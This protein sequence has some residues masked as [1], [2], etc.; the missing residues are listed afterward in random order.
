MNGDYVGMAMCWGP[1]AN[2][3]VAWKPKKASKSRRTESLLRIEVKAEDIAGPPAWE[4]NVVAVKAPEQIACFWLD[5]MSDN[6]DSSI[7]SEGDSQFTSSDVSE[8]SDS[9]PD[10]TGN[11]NNTKDAE[12]LTRLLG[13][14]Q[15]TK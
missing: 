12:F 5:D 8:T 10:N 2:V 15:V 9:Q 13:T 14:V 4:D 3:N 11:S 6:D 7:M 1:S